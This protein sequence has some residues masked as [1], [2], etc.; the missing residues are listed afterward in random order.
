MV[1]AVIVPIFLL[2]ALGYL[3]A[4]LNLLSK[5]QVEVIGSFVIKIALPALMFQSLATKDFKDIWLPDY[6][7]VFTAAAFLCYGLGFYLSLQHFKQHMSQASI[8]ALG[9]SM[10]NTGLIGTAVLSLLLGSKAMT[11]I[12]PILILE[13]VLLIPL[14][15]ILIEMGR[16][17]GASV[18]AVLQST[19]VMLLKTPLFVAVIVGILFA[20]LHIPMPTHLNAVLDMLGHTASP[21]ALF[22]IGGGIVGMSLKYMNLQTLYLVFSNNILMP[23]LVYVGLRYGVN[24]SQEMVYAGTIIAALPMPTIFAIL[25]QLNGLKDEALTP[26]LISTIVGFAGISFLIALW[27]G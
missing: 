12:V 13:S 5:A 27:Y 1:F 20:V 22:A 26:L 7:L 14:V 11:Y 2:L 16:H 3:A 6:F 15:L 25:G 18:L 24:A 9:A 19:F 17:K 10:S 8:L 23:V 4:K 21:L